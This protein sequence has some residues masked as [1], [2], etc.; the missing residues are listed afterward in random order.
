MVEGRSRVVFEWI[1]VMVKTLFALILVCVLAGC[2]LIQQMMPSHREAQRQ[3][4]QLQS[5]QLE[6]MRF[7]DEYRNRIEEAL[8]DF[9]QQ[10]HTPEDRLRAQNWKLLQVESVYLIAS[11]PNPLTNTL[12]LVV[13]ASLSRMVLDD[14]GITE[15]FGELTR[16]VR[17]AHS[18]METRAWELA[19]QVLTPSQAAELRALMVSWREHNPT[20]RRV[21][22]IHF[23]DFAR[24][25]GIPKEGEE[26][27]LGSLFS[28]VGLDPFSSLDPA[29]REIAQ[30]RQLAERSIFY[31]QRM[32][33]LVD[34][35]LDR[36]T[37]EVAVMPET[38]R[39]LASFDRFSL[40]GSAA[41]R[42]STELPHMFAAE[43]KALLLQLAQELN[44]QRDTVGALSNDVRETLKA[45]TETLNALQGALDTM[46]RI[47]AR[48]ESTTE[49]SSLQPQR[50]FDIREYNE[51]LRELT[52]TTRELSTFAKNLETTLPN[53]R[54]TTEHMASD[55][56][57]TL[58]HAFVL[59]LVLV[60]AAAL[61]SLAAAIAYRAIVGRMRTAAQA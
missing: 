27:K 20:V 56:E 12:D 9:Q 1:V 49:A 16:P 59:V 25:M 50:P 61:A 41:D 21:G 51:M 17:D 13:L 26:P 48:H 57:R 39:L 42:L 60:L 18:L 10:V 14:V 29:I 31:L 7:A 35:Q 5:L 15:H 37:D 22:A 40:A 47:S 19:D 52:T 23:T 33:A 28:L 34:M 2:T 4:E 30:T 46:D 36:F 8:R 24:S 53:L 45:G 55:L 43:R 3:T 32:P 44:A 6:V 58:N 38:K 54:A 11:G